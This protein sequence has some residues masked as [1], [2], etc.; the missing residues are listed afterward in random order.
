[1]PDIADI[2][3]LETRK[4]VMAE[5]EKIEEFVKLFSEAGMDANDPRKILDSIDPNMSAQLKSRVLEY[6]D[7][8]EAEA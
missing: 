5:K 7:A 6:L 4:V 2:M 8:A 3:D 1:M